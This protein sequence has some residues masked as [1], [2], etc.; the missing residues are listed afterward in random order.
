MVDCTTRALLLCDLLVT[1]EENV[2]AGGAGSAVNEALA[3]L[4][5]HVPV[6]NLGV[7]DKFISPDK[8]A[9]M[10]ATCGLD[11]AG[12]IEA[13]NARLPQEATPQVSTHG[14]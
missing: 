14:T 2:I 5:I 11:E 9:S 12:I 10:L 7:P 1:V 3:A 13:I 8:P 6:L 4:E